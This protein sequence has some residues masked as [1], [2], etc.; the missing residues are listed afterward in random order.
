MQA[1]AQLPGTLESLKIRARRD[2]LLEV[3]LDERGQVTLVKVLPPAKTRDL[4]TA[5]VR[6]AYASRYSPAMVNC[7]PRRGQTLF[8]VVYDP[9][10]E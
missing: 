10:A 3:L 4:D 6:S 5:A 8:P 1:Q 2:V 7:K 9:A